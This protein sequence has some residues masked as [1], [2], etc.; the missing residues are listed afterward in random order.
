MERKGLPARARATSL[1]TPKR[2]LAF[3]GT[4]AVELLLTHP[5]RWS[6]QRTRANRT[7]PEEPLSRR[8]RRVGSVIGEQREE[9]CVIPL[10][11]TAA[12]EPLLHALALKADP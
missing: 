5:K 7:R 4:V 8:L 9:R 2:G 10:L 11:V 1:R 3:L 12:Q 6:D